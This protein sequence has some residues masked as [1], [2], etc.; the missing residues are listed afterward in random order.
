MRRLLI[1]AACAIL[2]GLLSAGIANAHGGVDV[3][4]PG[5][6]S[7]VP[8]GRDHLEMSFVDALAADK[9]QRVELLDAQNRDQIT[10]GIKTGGNKITAALHP[11]KAGLHKV[12]YSVVLVDGH[13][14]TGSYYFSV[15][16]VPE[17]GKSDVTP[18]VIGGAVAAVVLLG[19]VIVVFLRRRKT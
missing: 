19:V 12:R 15:F 17:D 6:G 4:D 2:T 7:K 1:I 11:L 13:E 3:A 9:P 16:P 5:P 8:A 18:W 10:G 14:T